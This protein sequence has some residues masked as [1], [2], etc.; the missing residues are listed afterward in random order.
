[1]KIQHTPRLAEHARRFRHPF[2]F[3]GLAPAV[4]TVLFATALS[5]TAAIR[6]PVL[7]DDADSTLVSFPY[8]NDD[9]PFFETILSD[10]AQGGSYKLLHAFVEIAL[11]V[12]QEGLYRLFVK[13]PPGDASSEARWQVRESSPTGYVSREVLVNLAE[14][15]GDWRFL[16]EFQLGA[17]SRVATY[18]ADDNYYGGFG[19]TPGE[20]IFD[21]LRVEPVS[22]PVTRV[23]GP[24]HGEYLASGETIVI[25]AEVSLRDW[26][27]YYNDGPFSYWDVTA[28]PESD[29]AGIFWSALY[30]RPDAVGGYIK[31]SST[32][33]NFNAD[34]T[35][36]ATRY[37]N[38]KVKHPGTYHVY[39]RR[40][41]PDQG[42]NS[43]YFRF[44]SSTWTDNGAPNG[45]AWTWVHLGSQTLLGNDRRYGFSIGRRETGYAID[46]IVIS[47]QPMPTGNGPA[48]SL[49]E[50]SHF[51]LG[52]SKRIEAEDADNAFVLDA[53]GALAYSPGFAPFVVENSQ[54]PGTPGVPPASGPQTYVVWNG[55]KFELDA[56]P[57]DSASGVAE[58]AFAARAGVL[59]IHVRG[60][61][62]DAADNSIYYKL[63]PLDTT[64]RQF[65]ALNQNPNAF[66]EFLLGGWTAQ[67]DGIYRLKIQKRE[68]GARVESFR[69]QSEVPP[70]PAP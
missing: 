45:G 57:D 10:Q 21:A 59:S 6:P 29:A 42:S 26:H 70:P 24:G 27:P 41:A 69:I 36:T 55:G 7:I 19:W 12:E 2:G 66:E 58:Y 38:F 25:E 51:G 68:T 43:A 32:A 35:N 46:R 1:M 30:D 18:P 63:E 4:C 60:L 54:Q 48:E 9:N 17:Q 52:A 31:T 50:F 65:S 44:G 34:P 8:P 40:S 56:N 53:A 64:W 11:P 13:S 16:G 5:A 3:A 14:G 15:N 61:F 22:T 20:A 62:A 67:F 39:V 37:Y 49:R 47:T 33:F 28:G 23:G